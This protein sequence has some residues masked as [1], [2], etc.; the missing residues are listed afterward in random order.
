MT[1]DYLWNYAL[2]APLTF[3]CTLTNTSFTS[4]LFIASYLKKEKKKKALTF[5][6]PITFIFFS[7]Y[8]SKWHF[9]KIPIIFAL[10]CSLYRRLIFAQ[11]DY[12]YCNDWG[13]CCNLHFIDINHAFP[14]HCRS[15]WLR[16]RLCILNCIDILYIADYNAQ[17]Y[18]LSG[19]PPFL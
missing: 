8:F 3:L 13:L 17:Y 16:H 7:F 19:G 9:L 6:R 12:Y 1:Y 5:Y 14:L 15:V 2:I 4:L 18:E 10:P 11:C